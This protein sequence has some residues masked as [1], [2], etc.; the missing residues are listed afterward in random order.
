MKE[1]VLR[2][3]EGD[4]AVLVVSLTLASHCHPDRDAA[5][6]ASSTRDLSSM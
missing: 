1:Q 2:F 3:V 6:F 4:A 5:H